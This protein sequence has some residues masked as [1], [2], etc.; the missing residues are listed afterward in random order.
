MG[1]FQHLGATLS[2]LNKI[3]LH[4][5]IAKKEKIL[6]KLKMNQPCAMWSNILSIVL[7]AMDCVHLALC[8]STTV[9]NCWTSHLYFTCVPPGK[10]FR[11]MVLQGTQNTAAILACS[12]VLT[13]VTHL[14]LLQTIPIFNLCDLTNLIH[15]KIERYYGPNHLILPC[16][17]E[18]FIGLEISGNLTLPESLKRLILYGVQPVQII[19]LDKHPNLTILHRG[20]SSGS[21]SFDFPP[22]LAYLRMPRFPKVQKFPETLRIFKVLDSISCEEE[23]VFPATMEEL[24]LMSVDSPV[25]ESAPRRLHTLALRSF[26]TMSGELIFECSALTKIVMYGHSYLSYF[27]VRKSLEM[28]SGFVLNVMDLSFRSSHANFCIENLPF[29]KLKRLTI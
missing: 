24:D 5:I 21:N 19:G 23:V 11:K 15:L 6:F 20:T 2:S 1:S 26:N 16:C 3:S 12:P 4:A 22:K 28:I 17:L 7:P 13:C 9:K 8:N 14:Q 25:F 18:T 27:E 29:N 10:R